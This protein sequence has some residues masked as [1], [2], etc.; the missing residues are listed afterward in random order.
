LIWVPPER[1]RR[2]VPTR[3]LTSGALAPKSLKD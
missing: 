1:G 2:R 3:S